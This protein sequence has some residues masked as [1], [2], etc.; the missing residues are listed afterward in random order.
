M[1]SYYFMKAY[2]YICAKYESFF[3]NTKSVITPEAIVL[4]RV[5]RKTKQPTDLQELR[6]TTA[7]AAVFTSCAMSTR[8]YSRLIFEKM[9]FSTYIIDRVV[10][11]NQFKNVILYVHGGG[12]VSGTPDA[13]NSVY[14]IISE[15]KNTVVD[16]FGVNYP[17]L[18]EFTVEKAVSDVVDAFKFVVSQKYK[19]VIL[20][21]DDAGCNLILLSLANHIQKEEVLRN[22]VH[23]LI[24]FSPWTDLTMS[25]KSFRERVNIDVCFSKQFGTTL[26]SVL[27]LTQEEKIKYSFNHLIKKKDFQFELGPTTRIFVSYSDCERTAD[28]CEDLSNFLKKRFDERCTIRI[29]RGLPIHGF[30][31]WAP[32]IPEAVAVCREASRY[33]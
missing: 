27:D 24:L 29:Q 8:R 1:S 2:I 5:L 9:N 6:S 20:M 19:S 33:V 16:F 21:G 4:G 7:G 13:G 31:L 10:K 26:E 30:Q 14:K 11:Q 18:P 23:S 22:K 12:L 28:E 25:T 15:Q 17:V 32:L 3:G